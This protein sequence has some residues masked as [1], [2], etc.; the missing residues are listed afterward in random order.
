MSYLFNFLIK[1]PMRNLSIIC[2]LRFGLRVKG[3]LAM[4]EV[5]MMHEKFGLRWARHLHLSR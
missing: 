2:T 5:P 4:G 1:P 3:D